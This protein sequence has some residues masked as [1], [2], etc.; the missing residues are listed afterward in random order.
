LPFLVRGAELD[1]RRSAEIGM[2]ADGERMARVHLGHL[3]DRD[4]IGE[5]VHPGAAELL[6]PRHAKEAE[7]AHGLDVL[8]REFGVPV[9]LA[10]HG[11]DVAPGEIPDHLADLVV[12]VGEVE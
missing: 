5:L 9:E 4:V 12:M 8:P 6:A 2:G 7:L 1:D 11:R 10:R 3:V